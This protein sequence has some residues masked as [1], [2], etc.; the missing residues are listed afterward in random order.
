MTTET[1]LRSFVDEG[2]VILEG[3]LD[4][5]ELADITAALAPYE[6]DRP[7]GRNDFEGDRSQRVYSL[8]AKGAAFQRLAEHPRIVELLDRVLL[9]NYLLSTMQSIRL[10]PGE[11]AQAWHT[12]DAFYLLPR[13]RPSVLGVSVIWAIEDFTEENGATEIIPGS[14]RWA[15]DHP[16]ERAHEER[17]AVMPAGSAIVFDAALWHRGGENRSAGTRLAI[18]PQYCQP[19]LRPQ[20]S[21]LLIVPPDAARACSA[22]MRSL[23]GYSI[24]PPF[25]GQVDG[26]H[27]LRLVDDAYRLHKT[28]DREI[29]D[30]VLTRPGAEMRAA[31]RERD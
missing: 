11:N 6:R 10:H 7:M 16:D 5:T 31:A 28:R 1:R 14:H 21:Q 20:E 29:A 24:H 30:E 27:P 12:D 4:R 19:W 15:G 26:M 9:P 22:R 2:Y 13:P 17:A 8:A 18:S 3:L 25:I 23:L